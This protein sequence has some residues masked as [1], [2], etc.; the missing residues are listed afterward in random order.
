[1]KYAISVIKNAIGEFERNRVRTFLTSLGIMIG[2]FSVVMLLAL[3]IG[4]KNYLEQQFEDIGSNVLFVFP[5]QGFGGGGSFGQAFSSFANSI[6]F[7]ERDYKNLKQL[8]T[9][10]Y[11]VPGYITTKQIESKYEKTAG[12][13]Q[14]VNDEYDELFNFEILAGEFLSRSD[15]SSRSKVGVIAE[16][17]ADELFDEPDDAVGQTVEVDSNLRI[18]IIG[19]VKDIG[20]PE[21]D[22][23]I[24]IPYTTTFLTINPDKTFLSIYIGV[25]DSSLVTQTKKD[26]EDILLRRYD[27]DQFSVIEPSEILDTVTQ[28]FS[29]V[30]GVLIAIGSVSLIVGGIGIMNIMYAS[31]TD[32]TREIGIRRSIG[33]TKSDIMIQFMAESTILSLLGG[34]VGLL[35]AG[36]IVLIVRPFFPLEINL[37]TVLVSLGI[38]SVIGI[39]FGSFPAR[40]AANLTPIEAIR[41]E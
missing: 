23:S 20:D 22:N 6:Q 3:G 13:I 18:K 9:A 24:M 11:V 32:R 34:L 36:I 17:L 25:S 28:I 31:V 1:M 8:S 40:S 10:D 41:Y 2:V 27:D 7:D 5:G 12:S 38:S 29:I 30:N 16:T 4:L 14:G 26:A 15:I 35:L 21:Q 39:F 37:S 33:A 19:L